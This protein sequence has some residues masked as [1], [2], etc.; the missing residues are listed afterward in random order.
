MLFP[1]WTQRVDSINAVGE[2][3]RAPEDMKVGVWESLCRMGV[4]I[5]DLMG[6]E[7]DDASAASRDGDE[8]WRRLRVRVKWVPCQGAASA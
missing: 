7:G 1:W 5:R 3:S 2:G 4:L 8:T 6:L